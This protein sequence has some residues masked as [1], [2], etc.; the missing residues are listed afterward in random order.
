M[1]GT[2]GPWGRQREPQETT[3][4]TPQELRAEWPNRR[5]AAPIDC[6]SSSKFLHPRVHQAANRFAEPRY[7]Y[8]GDI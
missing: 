7:F 2:R 1:H 4:T 3:G 5:E 8:Y 6:A